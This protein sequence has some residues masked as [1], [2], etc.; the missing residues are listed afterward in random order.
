M[1]L[2][3]TQAADDFTVAKTVGDTLN[4]AYPGYLWAVHCSHEQGV[5]VI[6][7]M[8]M[9]PAWGYVIHTGKVFSVSDLEHK[10]KVG[11]GEMLE[12]FRL[13]RGAMDEGEVQARPA[14]A[15]GILI[16]DLS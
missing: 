2:L 11:A 10:A 13:R 9:P 4:A 16:G 15:R 3:E 6:K 5:I 1:I 7:S 14:D 8:M 12:R